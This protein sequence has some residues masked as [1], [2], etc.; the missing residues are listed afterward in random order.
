MGNH[1]PDIRPFHI[2]KVEVPTGVAAFPKE[3]LKAPRS[4]CEARYNLTRGA[5]MPRGGHVAAYEQPGLFVDDVR[6]FYGTVTR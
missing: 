4:W 2:G 3:I 1:E 6:A 5:D